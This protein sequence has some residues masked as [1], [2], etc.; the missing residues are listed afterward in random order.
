MKERQSRYTVDPKIMSDLY[1]TRGPFPS[2]FNDGS[3]YKLLS[4][5]ELG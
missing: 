3:G 5:V 2:Q 1:F 4:P